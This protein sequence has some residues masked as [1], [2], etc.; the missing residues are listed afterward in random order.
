MEIIVI[1]EG[2]KD[3]KHRWRCTFND[4]GN[5]RKWYCVKCRRVEED[6]K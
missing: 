5:I 3:C 1:N 4:Y 6:M 2:N